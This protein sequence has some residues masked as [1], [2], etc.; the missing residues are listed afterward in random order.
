MRQFTEAFIEHCHRLPEP[1]RAF[2]LATWD[3]T[4]RLLHRFTQKGKPWSP[5]TIELALRR[6]HEARI[7]KRHWIDGVRVPSIVRTCPTKEGR[8]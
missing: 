3:L 4:L 1:E 2:S 6:A 8:T 5:E 7:E